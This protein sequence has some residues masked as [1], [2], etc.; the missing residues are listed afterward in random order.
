[1]TGGQQQ[2]ARQALG[3]AAF[4]QEQVVVA[5]FQAVGVVTE[6]AGHGAMGVEIDHDH[7]LARLG[8]QP[9]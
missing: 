3:H 6:I 5:V 4:M 1:M 2:L 7:A 9:G 8:Q